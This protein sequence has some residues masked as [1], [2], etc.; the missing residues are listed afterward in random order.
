MSPNSGSAAHH[1]KADNQEV[2]IPTMHVINSLSDK[3]KKK[4]K[5]AR[6]NRKKGALI[7]KPGNLERRQTHVPRPTPEMLLSHDSVLFCLV[8]LFRLYPRRMD[9]PRLGPES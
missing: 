4:K 6:V 2:G 3:K 5:E 7:R 1:S 8:F 9:V